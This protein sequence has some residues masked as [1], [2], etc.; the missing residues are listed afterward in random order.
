MFL[1]TKKKITK[2]RFFFNAY[3]QPYFFLERI[4]WRQHVCKAATKSDP[5]QIG[6]SKPKLVMPTPLIRSGSRGTFQ[7]SHKPS[8]WRGLVAGG[9]DSASVGWIFFSCERYR[10]EKKSFVVL[11][12]TSAVAF[13]SRPHLHP[14]TFSASKSLLSHQHPNLFHLLQTS[15][16][17]MQMKIDIFTKCG[18]CCSFVLCCI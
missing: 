10:I 4:V 11:K 17:K 6:S 15:R 18:E 1:N 12:Y 13:S 9:E 2:K 7:S 16:Y 14:A 3:N 8:T 5:P